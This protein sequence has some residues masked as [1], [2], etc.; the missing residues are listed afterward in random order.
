[1]PVR[2]LIDE[3]HVENGSIQDPSVVRHGSV[4]AGSVEALAG[5]ID[6]DAHLNP[7]VDHDLDRC[8][9]VESLEVGAPVL[10][11]GDTWKWASLKQ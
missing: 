6:V 8:L 2:H 5:T 11:E 1:M 10:T 3:D 4:R 7:S 9:V